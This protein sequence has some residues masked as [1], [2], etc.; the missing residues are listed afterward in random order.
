MRERE[1]EIMR[2]SEEERVRGGIMGELEE[3]VGRDNER[4]GDIIRKN[5]RKEGKKR[6]VGR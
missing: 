5:E 6:E 2:E 1:G 3:V 4:E